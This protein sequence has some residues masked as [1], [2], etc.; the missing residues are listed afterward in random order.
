MA[1]PRIILA[2]TDVQYLLSIQLKFVEEFYEKIDLEIIT[3]QEYFENL[4]ML[5]QRAD[6]LVVSENLYTV[7]LQKHNIS[8]VF[9]MT[10]Q[11]E[12]EGTQDLNITKIY[13][14]T[15]IKEIFNIIAGKAANDLN[16][17]EMDKKGSQI[18]V[19]TSASG[20]VGKTT[21]AMGL[22]AALS[23]DYKKTLYIDCEQLQVF[24][25][26][27]RNTSAISNSE[28]Y[29]KF[30]HNNKII[31]D[32]IKHLIR[33]EGFSYIPPFK[34]ALMALGISENIYEKIVVAAKEAKEYDFIILDTDHV[35]NESKAKLLNLADKVICVVGQNRNSILA[36][37][38]LVDN[39]NGLSTDKYYFI[40]NDF[41]S[42]RENAITSPDIIMKFSV[43]DYMEHISGYDEI[44]GV[45]LQNQ[46]G[47]KKIA[48]LLE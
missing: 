29:M 45:D 6:V 2:D 34:S 15:S 46:T 18:V 43:N 42:D 19:V 16:V 12:E 31:F 26:L 41:S 1:R 39:I 10:E 9:M 5:P 21:V 33:T 20:G 25:G 22:A 7:S 27:L 24:S 36:T 38:I 14:Y 32:D 3:D 30:M 44:K 13:K 23:K 48:Y 37:N 28:I 35:F 40:C 47:I 17:G 4:F 8:H 11:Q